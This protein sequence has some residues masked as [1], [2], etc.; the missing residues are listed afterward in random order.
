MENHGSSGVV[1]GRQRRAPDCYSR[2]IFA[3]SPRDETPGGSA[4]R[5]IGSAGEPATPKQ[6][7]LGRTGVFASRWC[8][9]AWAAGRLSRRRSGRRSVHLPGAGGEANGPPGG[10]AS[11][12]AGGSSSRVSCGVTARACRR[13]STSEELTEG[14]LYS[15]RVRYSP[16]A[17]IDRPWALNIRSTTGVPT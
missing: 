6:G 17:G 15:G 5:T 10:W 7:S 2:G 16:M 9:R 12:P 11:G 1:R 8:S 13:R 14:D 3:G 4:R